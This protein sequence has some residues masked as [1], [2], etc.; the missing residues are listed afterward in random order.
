[1]KRKRRKNRTRRNAGRNWYAIKRGTVWFGRH[2]QWA[3]P[4]APYKD[5]FGSFHEAYK[6]SSKA[7]AKK[8]ARKHGGAVTLIVGHNEFHA[9]RYERLVNPGKRA[10]TKRLHKA[11]SKARGKGVGRLARRILLRR[12]GYGKLMGLLTR[13]RR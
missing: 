8:D 10:S 13:S 7:E 6:Y 11:L 5:G 12:G 2:Y 4:S 9:P 3:S 1:M